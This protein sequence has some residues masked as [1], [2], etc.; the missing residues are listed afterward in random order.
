MRAKLASEFANGQS[1]R[2]LCQFQLN[3]FESFNS[4]I[5]FSGHVVTPRASCILLNVSTLTHHYNIEVSQS[6]RRFGKMRAIFEERRKFIRRIGKARWNEVLKS[7]EWSLQ[8]AR[9]TISVPSPERVLEQSKMVYVLEERKDPSTCCLLFQFHQ[10]DKRCCNLNSSI[11]ML[12]QP[13][14]DYKPIRN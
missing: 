12:S 8:G 3:L 5:R 10:Q 7:L 9:I 11:K 6:K 13:K 14:R 2:T 4:R 1:T